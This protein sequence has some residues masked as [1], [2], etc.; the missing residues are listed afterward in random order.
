MIIDTTF[1]KPKS[2]HDNLMM[3]INTFTIMRNYWHEY[4]YILPSSSKR[5]I[6][7]YYG[8]KYSE[9]ITLCKAM[10]NNVKYY[11][12]AQYYFHVEENIKLAHEYAKIGKDKG[13]LTCEILD[14]T[15][16][17]PNADCTIYVNHSNTLLKVIMML[18]AKRYEESVKRLINEDND[19]M[20]CLLIMYYVFIEQN[21]EEAIKIISSNNIYN[22]K[23]ARTIN[24]QSGEM[25]YC[26]GIH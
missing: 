4:K 11:L 25:R 17:T 8:G 3:M 5:A 22:I 7:C 15:L 26:L 23:W 19:D 9:C 24:W 21:I 6:D 20:Q 12:L 13:F 18:K 10:D 14:L 1:L 2:N 16:N